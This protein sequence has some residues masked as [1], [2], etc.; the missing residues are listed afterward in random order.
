MGEGSEMCMGARTSS[1]GGWEASEIIER[2]KRARVGAD[3]RGRKEGHDGGV[4]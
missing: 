4:Y 3:G 2:R 1:R